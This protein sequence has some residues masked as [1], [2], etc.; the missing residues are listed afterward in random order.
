[1]TAD[2]RPPIRDRLPLRHALLLGLIHGPTELLPVSSSGHTTLIPWLARWPYSEL[3]AETHKSF[4]VALHAGTALALALGARREIFAELGNLNRRRGTLIALSL[5]PPALA[6]YVFER[7]IERH[8]GGPRSIA[9]GLL[10]GAIAMALADRRA[11]DQPAET[12]P[13]HRSKL[14]FSVGKAP[15]RRRVLSEAGASDGLALGLA[16]SVALIP[17]ISR[18]G[19][20]LTAARLRGF[21]RGD[22]QA[23]SWTVALPVIASASVLKGYRLAHGGVSRSLAAPLTVGAAASFLS[24]RAGLAAVRGRR[25]NQSLLPY[26]LYRCALALLTARRMRPTSRNPSRR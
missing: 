20:T 9:F 19:A 16:Q 8:L 21:D 13:S 12:R 2:L 18:N 7:P 4:E 17:G 10:A 25:R 15:R 22:S 23:L 24:T 3:D 5:A 26:S 1:M 14:A 6:G 11:Q